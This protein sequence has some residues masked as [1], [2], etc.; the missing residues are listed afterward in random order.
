MSNYFYGAYHWD[1][2]PVEDRVS[3]LN[4]LQVFCD[5]ETN[6]FIES[7]SPTLL[8]RFRF[9]RMRS[10]YQTH[11]IPDTLSPQPSIFH[12]TLTHATIESLKKM[13]IRDGLNE[14]SIAH[15]KGY[16][17]NRGLF[18]FHGF[19]DAPDQTLSC[20]RHVDDATIEQLE[21]LLGLKA[22]KKYGQ[23]KSD[24]EQMEY[25]ESIFAAMER[26]RDSEQ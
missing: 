8:Q 19:C 3:L 13:V 18:W 16:S 7:L 23:L 14:Q 15:I 6:L 22:E 5:G 10:S 21:S 1:F 17:G 2:S 11:L 12:L 4:A 24:R 9:W 20:S 26:S 25:L